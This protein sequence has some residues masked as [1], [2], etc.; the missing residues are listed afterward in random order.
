MQKTPSSCSTSRE[1]I[2]PEFGRTRLDQERPRTGHRDDVCEIIKKSNVFI[3]SFPTSKARL[4]TSPGAD[5]VKID[6]DLN[7]SYNTLRVFLREPVAEDVR[8]QVSDNNKL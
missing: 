7:E 2:I 6:P 8:G 4:G 3:S 5:D 1:R